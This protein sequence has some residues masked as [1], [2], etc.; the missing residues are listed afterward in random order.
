MTYIPTSDRMLLQA[1][2]AGDIT[3]ENDRP[4]N[5]FKQDYAFV[6]RGQTVD[7]ATNDAL[8]ALERLGLFVHR[9]GLPLTDAGRAVLTG[10]AA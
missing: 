2:A 10:G 7:K 1:I 5:Y 9:V 6:W 3:W 4:D 8:Y